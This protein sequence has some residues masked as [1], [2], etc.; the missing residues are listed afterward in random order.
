MFEMA[1]KNTWNKRNNIWNKLNWKCIINGLNFNKL[2]ENFYKIQATCSRT[3]IKI[4]RSRI[5]ITLKDNLLT[6]LYISKI[7]IRHYF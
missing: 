1:A 2:M 6:V 3:K 4:K 7:L 5:Q